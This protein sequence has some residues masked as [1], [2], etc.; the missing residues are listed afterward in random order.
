MKTTLF[1]FVLTVSLGA[2]RAQDADYYN[3]SDY[4]SD[5]TPAV[6]YDAPAVV[7]NAPVVYAAPVVYNLPVVYNAPV[8]YGLPMMA[9]GCALNA[10]SAACND[11]SFHARSTVTYIG[12]G[13]VSYQVSAACNTGSTLV[14]IGGSWFH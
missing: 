6:V 7:Y 3:Y 12:G 10:C 9:M 14:F 11:Y 13:H 1:L 5:Q 8:Y 2:A 4:S